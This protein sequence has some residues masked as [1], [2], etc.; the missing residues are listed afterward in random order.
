LIGS[1][2]A[3]CCGQRLDHTRIEQSN[4]CAEADHDGTASCTECLLEQPPKATQQSIKW[5]HKHLVEVAS[6]PAK[7]AAGDGL[8]LLEHGGEQLPHWFQGSLYRLKNVLRKCRAKPGDE[9][10]RDLHYP[11]PQTNPELTDRFT[12][13]H[14]ALHPL[15]DGRHRS[16]Q[17]SHDLIT[18]DPDCRRSSH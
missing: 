6:P 11:L 10:H 14:Q 9:P 5:F 2:T 18:E 3:D 4:Q 8:H 13:L 7:E 17:A 15:A 1:T 16:L 12:P